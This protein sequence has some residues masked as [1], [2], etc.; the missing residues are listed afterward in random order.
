MEA[1]RLA[2]LLVT[3]ALAPAPAA[4]VAPRGPVAY[5]GT[6]AWIDR[7]DFATLEDPSLV[8]A[9]LAS[10]G[11]RTLFLATGSWRTPSNIDIEAPSQTARLIST[12]HAR[13]MKVVA[14]YVPDFKHLR[15]DMRRVKAAVGFRTDDGQAFDSFALDIEATAVTPLAR[16][17]AALLKLSR[18]MRMAVGR[19]YPLGAI[20][21]DELSTTRGG[22]LWPGFPYARVAKYYD[23]FLPMA[24]STLNRAHGP[25]RVYMYTRANVRFVRRATHR[26]VHLIAGVTDAMTPAEQAVAATAARDAG[27]I[28]TSLYKYKLY[29]TASWAALS[30][31]DTAQPQALRSP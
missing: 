2:A 5:S 28:G 15:R 13:G 29:D 6:G 3:L 20:I 7:Y 21:P 17:N 23:V 10:H 12:A 18:W 19:H 11:V 8:V 24:Y 25:G 16:R 1:I 4:P 26:P 14:W 27:A 30:A 31:F 22:G 9:D